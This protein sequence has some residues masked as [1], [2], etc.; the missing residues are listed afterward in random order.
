MVKIGAFSIDKKWG[1]FRTPWY[2]YY[3]LYCDEVEILVDNIPEGKDVYEKFVNVSP[4]LE[5]KM[6]ELFTR[7]D[8]VIYADIDE[9]IVPNPTEY[10]HLRD[11]VEKFCH[12]PQE[13]VRCTGMNVVQIIGE[14]KINWDEPFLVQRRYWSEATFYNKFNICKVPHRFVDGMVNAH[15]PTT[16]A[17]HDLVLMHMKYL[18]FEEEVK[19]GKERRGYKDYNKLMDTWL[20]VTKKA[21]LIPDKYK[22]I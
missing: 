21:E 10:G 6:V 14:D 7:N 22:I 2:N 11:Y 15:I 9:F 17:D 18:D 13:E 1:D 19:R 5:Q 4:V 12:Y 20:D 3:S 8:V 16:Q